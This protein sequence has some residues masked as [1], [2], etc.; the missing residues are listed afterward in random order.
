MPAT[1][2]DPARLRKLFDLSSEVYDSRG[3]TFAVDPYPVFHERRRSGPVH[4]GIVHEHLGFAGSPV[5]QGLPYPTRPHFSVYDYE[6]CARVFKDEAFITNPPRLAGEPGLPDVAILFMDGK[7]HRSHRALVQPSFVPNRAVWWL[8]NWIESTVH[9]LID[10]FVG[11]GRA[12]LN[13]EFCA[14]IPLLTITGSFGVDIDQA[15]DIRAAVTQDQ[16]LEALSA[17]LGPIISARRVEPRDDLISVLVHAELTDEDGVQHRLSDAEVFAFSFLLLAAGSGTTWKQMGITLLALLRDA[18][19]LEAVRADR[20]LLKPA[21]EEGLRWTPTDPVFARFAAEDVELAGVTVP[22]G[23]VIHVC[24]AG[25]NRDPAR[26]DRPD[27]YDPF[28]PLQPHLGFGGGS[29]ICLGM[30]VARA[31]MAAGIGALLDR[32]ADL[33]LDLDAP[34]PRIVGLYERGPT[35]V[36]VRFG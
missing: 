33:R 4:S 23:S 7:R 18:E 25:A 3:G 30:H 16:G 36:P 6:T 11:H 27:A 29:H 34:E 35:A 21:I 2:L 26:W 17:I 1:A 10:N 8:D 15:L 28:R 12:D 19:A 9:Q 14:P 24:L 13:V 32:L 5:F 22:V 31:E 20:A